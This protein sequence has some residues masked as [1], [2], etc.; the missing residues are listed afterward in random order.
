MPRT[1]VPIS[2]PA[3]TP[4]AHQSPITRAQGRFPADGRNAGGGSDE[5]V[6]VHRP[7]GKAGR[8]W[9]ASRSPRINRQ[10]LAVSC[11][12]FRA[13]TQ[14]ADRARSSRRL[15]SCSPFTLRWPTAGEVGHSLGCDG[16][17]LS[18]QLRPWLGGRTRTAVPRV[19]A[20]TDPRCEHWVSPSNMPSPR[21]SR[22]A[23]RLPLSLFLGV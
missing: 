21:S 18:L 7:P 17:W 11:P 6:V 4:L 3:G 12:D 13:R 19:V 23:H 20:A 1:G 22:R 10:S 5:V 2:R 9:A 14:L 8:Q 16:G 15:S